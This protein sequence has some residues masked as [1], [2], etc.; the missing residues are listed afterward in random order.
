MNM[1][2]EAVYT[3]HYEEAGEEVAAAAAVVVVVTLATVEGTFCWPF[4]CTLW[5]SAYSGSESSPR[6]IEG[7]RSHKKKAC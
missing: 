4:A 2:I 3:R 6:E 7:K 5:M 1:A